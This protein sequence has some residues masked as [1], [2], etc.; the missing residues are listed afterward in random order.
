MKC[1][2]IGAG[3]F[4]NPKI[5]K[6]K[7]DLLICADGGYLYA[8]KLDLK[9][10]LLVGDFDSL[11][12][13]P[14]DVQTVKLNKIKDETDLYIAIEEGIKRGYQT[15]DIYGALGGRIE[16]TIANIQILANLKSKGLTAKLIDDKTIVEMLSTG[17]YIY[18]ERCGYISLFSYTKESTITIK[19]LLYEVNNKTISNEF[20]LGIDNEFIGK[21]STVTVH[22]GLVLSIINKKND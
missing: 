5:I 17:T 7:D 4:N 18:N 10:D 3:S 12:D 14:L 16:H 22:N 11:K 6:E 20:P 2:I 21:E 1:I 13:I 15:F 9:V 8:R 19:N